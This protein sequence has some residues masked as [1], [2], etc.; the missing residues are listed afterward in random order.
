MG[1]M[2][3]RRKVLPAACCAPAVLRAACTNSGNRGSPAAAQPAGRAGT[4]TAVRSL[5]FP[6]SL[7]LASIYADALAAESFLL[8]ILPNLGTRELVGTALV[9]D[10][11]QLVPE[12]V[13]SAQDFMSLDGVRR[14]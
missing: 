11:I 14:R 12:Y 10:L 4:L 3:E 13:G 5:D 6:E 1:E 2:F 8:R 9:N 7:L